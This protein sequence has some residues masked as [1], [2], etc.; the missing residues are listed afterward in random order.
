MSVFTDNQ[1]GLYQ[2]GKKVGC[3]VELVGK[4]TRVV[5]DNSKYSASGRMF[6]GV[7][8]FGGLAGEYNFVNG[9][10]EGVVGGAEWR[11]A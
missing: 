5:L 10:H 9:V 4:V 7:P 8:G 2:G 11:T 1:V 6:V 3:V